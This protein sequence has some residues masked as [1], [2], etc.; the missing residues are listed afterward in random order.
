MTDELMNVLEFYK[1]GDIT[2]EAAE[3]EIGRLLTGRYY[4]DVIF[5][6]L[7]NKNNSSYIAM[8]IPEKIND[9]LKVYFVIDKNVIDTR[10]S[11]ENAYK[12]LKVMSNFCVEAVIFYLQFLRINKDIETTFLDCVQFYI[13]LYLKLLNKIPED[14]MDNIN[15]FKKFAMH[16]TSNILLAIQSGNERSDSI[17]NYIL[18]NHTLPKFALD[19]AEKLFKSVNIPDTEVDKRVLSQDL[20]ESN[21]MYADVASQS[22]GVINPEWRQDI[23]PN[24]LPER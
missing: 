6:D 5:D 24:Y 2:K 10:L 7:E 13:N 15:D 4:I 1:S 16:D 20:P 8:V 14:I 9:D 21:L 23:D 22:T 11:T 12:L 3:K 18:L 17:I 19:Q